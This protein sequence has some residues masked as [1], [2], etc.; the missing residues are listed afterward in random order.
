ML[1]ISVRTEYFACAVKFRGL[2]YQ[3]LL[4]PVS[5]GQEHICNLAFGIYLK[6]S[7]EV[8]T[9][10]PQGLGLSHVILI[11]KIKQLFGDLENICFQVY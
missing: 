5:L 6:I 1:E 3:V 2:K 11:S 9:I 10:V 7:Q 4:I 8:T